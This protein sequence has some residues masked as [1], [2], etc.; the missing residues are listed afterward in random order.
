[1]PPEAVREAIR[2]GGLA[3]LL[4]R[5]RVA[6]GEAYLVPAGTLH[7]IGPGVLAYE[8]Q[9]PSDITYRCDDWGRPASA[10]RPLHVE[11]SLVCVRPG[12]W[13]ESVRSSAGIDARG[14]LVD[15]WHHGTP[16]STARPWRAS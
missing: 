9:Q 12:P 10:G 4:Q 7:A 8:I 16:V 13:T 2:G 6:A 5:Q 3:D 11:Q 1:M 14:L 15:R